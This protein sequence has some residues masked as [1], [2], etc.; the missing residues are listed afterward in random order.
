M[1]ITRRDFLK[2]SALISTWAALSACRITEQFLGV[3]S[4]ASDSPQTDF[5]SSPP[6]TDKALLLHTLR[7]I[8]FAQTPEMIEHA[9]KV[10]LDAFIEEQL[11]PE[12]IPDE[13]T[14]KML[15][16]FPTLSMTT[17]ERLLIERRAE[18]V[19]ELIK[20]TLLQQMFSQRQLFEMM[21]DFWSNHF[22]IYIGKNLCKVFKTD[23]DQKV[24]RPNAL[25][26]FRALLHA[27][28]HSPAML[29]Y[30]DQ[31]TSRAAAPNENYARELMELHTIGVA[32]GFT[33]KDVEEVARVLTGWSVVRPRNDRSNLDSGQFVFNARNHAHGDKTVLGLHIAE[34]GEDEGLQLLDMLAAHPNTAL[35]IGEKL[36]RRFITDRPSAA[37]VTSLAT[38][39]TESNGDIRTIL[40]TL[41]S[42][43]EFKASAGQKF[44]RPLDFFISA[45]RVTGA[46]VNLEYRR[47]EQIQQHLRFMGQI[48]FTW[49]PPNG[50]PDVLDHWSTTSGLLAR[51]NFGVSLTSG[52]IRG[53][54]VNLPALTQDAGSAED[55]VDVLS[56]RFMGDILPDDARDILVDFTSQNDLD[57]V[58]PSVAG[59]IL[60]SP[61][62]QL[63]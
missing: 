46:Q 58:I 16:N 42:S 7:R 41:F 30:L 12:S 4:D 10:G 6:L 22:N 19:A 33:S 61:H 55:V 25:E 5:A 38:V 52:H 27:S 15:K 40:R 62:F 59:L 31:A 24:I 49:T 3:V 23:D 26:T 51:W 21:V 34:G 39:F 32:G 11:N 35:I 9:Q 57:K 60:G 37:I 53:V 50:F 56:I 20:A 18:P 17:S 54:S 2:S 29:I 8:T 48:P 28:A 43:E 1:T 44:K 63:R 14:A 36:A 13:S 47:S 45:M